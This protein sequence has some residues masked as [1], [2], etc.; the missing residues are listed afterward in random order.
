MANGDLNIALR[1]P[2]RGEPILMSQKTSRKDRFQWIIDVSANRCSPEDAG[3]GGT[4]V[5]LD[6]EFLRKATS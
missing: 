3:R 6:L 5:N 4:L 2:A 1:A